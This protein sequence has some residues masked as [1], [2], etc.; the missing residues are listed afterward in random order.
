MH[1]AA[2]WKS[3]ERLKLSG[4]LLFQQSMR[5]VD[6]CN[7]WREYRIYRH[8][9]NTFLNFLSPFF[10]FLK[11]FWRAYFVHWIARKKGVKNFTE[12]SY[13]QCV[14]SRDLTTKEFF[15]PLDSPREL[16]LHPLQ[17]SFHWIMCEHGDINEP[18][19]ETTFLPTARNEF[20][21]CWCVEI[22]FFCVC[23]RCNVAL[24]Y[25]NICFKHLQGI[26]FFNWLSNN[27]QQWLK[28]F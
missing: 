12:F 1:Y 24:F 27:Q 10:S 11:M 28:V 25:I 6:L 17:N 20:N 2:N 15:H 4:D 14:L 19:H 13:T 9:T 5:L 26:S 7:C 23:A 21:F 18:Q 22:F 8:R 16:R 3:R